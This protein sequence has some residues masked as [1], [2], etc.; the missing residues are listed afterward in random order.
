MNPEHDFSGLAETLDLRGWA[1]DWNEA[2]W[3]L[4]AKARLL[5]DAAFLGRCA[6][7]WGPGKAQRL[8]SLI[9]A[10]PTVDT[11]RVAPMPVEKP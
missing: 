11:K 4:S 7:E 10:I 8:Q 6:Q 1:E 5:Q 3:L 9:S 2:V